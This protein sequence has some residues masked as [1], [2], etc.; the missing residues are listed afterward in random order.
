MDTIIEEESVGSR[1]H[2]YVQG[3]LV[4]A[5]AQLQKYVIFSELSLDIGGK[6]YKPDICLYSEEFNLKTED[7]QEDIL[8]MTDMPLCAIEILSPRQFMESLTEKFK[9]YF[10]AGVQSCWLVIPHLRLVSV[11]RDFKTYQM[12]YEGEIFD[13][14]LNIRLPLNKVFCQ[15]KHLD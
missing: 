2:S 11:Y 7:F 12:F 3:N 4:I 15:R 14:K 10:N 1:N 8:R 6:E 13:E 9:V 5:F